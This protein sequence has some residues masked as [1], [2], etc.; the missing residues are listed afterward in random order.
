M[1]VCPNYVYHQ[2]YAAAQDNEAT[3]ADQ[4]ASDSDAAQWR[5]MARTIGVRDERIT[6][7]D[8]ATRGTHYQ[9]KA[10]RTGGRHGW[11]PAAPYGAAG[12]HPC[13]MKEREAGDVSRVTRQAEQMRTASHAMLVSRRT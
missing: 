5:E 9:G 7:S 10:V 11:G 2:F 4:G 1:W 12:P 3:Y 6:R 8:C 13:P